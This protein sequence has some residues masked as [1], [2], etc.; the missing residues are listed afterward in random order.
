[1]KLSETIT[2]RD[3]QEEMVIKT[4]DAIDELESEQ[5]FGEPDS[6]TIIMKLLMSAGKTYTALALANELSKRGEK[7]GI[8]FPYKILVDQFAESAREANIEIGVISS[9]TKNPNPEANIQVCMIQTL[10]SMYRNNK[11]DIKFSKVIQDE[12]ASHFESG[13]V[14]D[15][16]ESLGYNIRIGMTG[17]DFTSQGYA[18]NAFKTIETIGPKG[19]VEQKAWHPNMKYN[20]ANF[21]EKMDWDKIKI[22]SNGEFNQA[23]LSEII[24]ADTYIHQAIKAMNSFNMKDDKTIVFTSSIHM[25]QK[26]TVALNEAGYSAKEYH[27]K[28][29]KKER[30][31]VLNSFINET[32]YKD[33]NNKQIALPG[34]REQEPEIIKCCVNVQALNVGFNVP[35]IK[36]LV[37]AT[38]M[39]SRIKHHQTIARLIRYHE[40]EEKIL[41]DCGSNISRNFFLD[42]TFTPVNRTENKQID[43]ANLA[44]ENAKWSLPLLNEFLSDDL[45]TEISRDWYD[46][47]LDNLR[48]IENSIFNNNQEEELVKEGTG[49]SN[50]DIDP[51]EVRIKHEQD[52]AKNMAMVLRTTDDLEHLAK[53]YI[54]FW[55][56]INGSPISKAGHKYV[57][58][59]EWFV[60]KWKADI[61]KYPEVRNRFMK[62]LK[63]RAK[64][65]IKEGKN[66]NS[67]SFFTNFLLT[68]YEN[69]IQQQDE[70][71]QLQFGSED[72][73]VMNEISEEECPF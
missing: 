31:A 19:L 51:E 3:Y 48:A 66:I 6:Y 69:E 9:G 12:V 25:A 45:T 5:A 49:S 43:K 50:R 68:N 38:S 70:Y 14:I 64:N 29:K 2:L 39:M 44:R 73:N 63:T 4:L 34:M 13:S 35:D 22:E 56:Y 7:I 15:L 23:Q 16:K 30:E 65:I 41:L 72:N 60:D 36:N 54:W 71:K 8:F 61:D 33:P 40:M 42:D 11:L 24:E 20:V 18:L 67:L 53:A 17:T 58:K 59:T 52:M 28:M 26:I 10:H 55:M 27:S 47:K 62:A 1:M 37:L 21:S 32:E 57:P 46:S